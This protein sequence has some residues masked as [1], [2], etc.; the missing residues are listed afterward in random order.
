MKKLLF[1][2]DDIDFLEGN[3]LYFCRKQY[4]VFCVNKP[5]DAISLLSSTAIDC[6][7]LDIDMPDITGFEVCQKIRKLSGT[8]IIFLSGLTDIKNRIASFQA[9]GDDFLA[10]PYDVLELELRIEARIR[11]NEQVFFSDIMRFG[12]LCIDENRRM[13][14]YKEKPG[15]FTALQFDIVAFMARNPGKVFS[16]EQL[17]DRIWKEPIVK[18]RHNL[19]V[20]V[21]TVRQKLSQLCDGKQYIRTVARKGYYFTFGESQAP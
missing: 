8:P 5:N 15:E 14:T 4:E 6:I 10:K 13:I 20:A 11:K 9:G 3:R 1:I 17:Y 2:D 16:Y 7:I 19:Q 12:D 18:S 21:A